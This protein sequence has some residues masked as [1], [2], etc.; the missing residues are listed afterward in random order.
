MIDERWRLNPPKPYIQT[1]QTGSEQG[2]RNLYGP[3]L[4]FRVPLDLDGDADDT[5]SS[6]PLH[7]TEGRAYYFRMEHSSSSSSAL[8]LL[9]L[10]MTKI[11]IETFTSTEITYVGDET[12]PVLPPLNMTDFLL[13]NPQGFTTCLTDYDDSTDIQSQ[14]ACQDA[15]YPICT[16]AENDGFNL[17]YGECYGYLYTEEEATD[18]YEQSFAAQNWNALSNLQET[19]LGQTPINTRGQA[20][21]SISDAVASKTSSVTT[22]SVVTKLDEWSTTFDFGSPYGHGLSMEFF[23]EIS[24]TNKTLVDDLGDLQ[25]KYSQH[26]S[27]DELDN[28]RVAEVEVKVGFAKSEHDGNLVAS[29][30]PPENKNGTTTSLFAPPDS[31]TFRYSWEETPIITSIFPT[32]G[33]VGDTITITGEQF[34]TIPSTFD[35]D[36]G[37]GKCIPTYANRTVVL[38]DLTVE[39][40]AGVWDVVVTQYREGSAM[41]SALNSGPMTFEVLMRVDSVFPND[42]SLYGGAAVTISGSGFANFGLYNKVVFHQPEWNLNV[43]CIPR[44]M[45]NFECQLSENDPGLECGPDFNFD[46]IDHYDNPIHSRGYSHFFDFSNKTQIECDME[47]IEIP[48][49]TKRS[50]NA[51]LDGLNWT[52]SVQLASEEILE[53]EEMLDND[54]VDVMRSYECWLIGPSCKMFSENFF[55]SDV[56][57]GDWYNFTGSRSTLGSAIN[58]NYNA[59]AVIEEA[60]TYD[61]DMNPYMP[62]DN[63]TLYAMAGQILTLRGHGFSKAFGATDKNY[64]KNRYSFFDQRGAEEIIVGER[65]CRTI[66]LNDT[67][68]KCV[69]YF[70]KEDVVDPIN[71][72]V[73][74]KGF[75]E[76]DWSVMFGLDIYDISPKWGSVMGGTEVTITGSGE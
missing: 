37:P 1:P 63:R 22:T 50:A 53:D 5:T 68:A 10:T 7:L 57:F 38:C 2:R 41:I 59:T 9:S 61:T 46:R 66:E 24:V 23:R 42:I 47:R 40:V 70:Q 72:Q 18:I 6:I 60:M 32:S 48:N 26:T 39:A 49:P 12:D 51:P 27:I 74:G 54:L 8:K 17:T 31:C 55:D 67:H 44:V 25:A 36:V 29:C 45:R 56:F 76:C 30:Y 21:I 14:L 62:Y 11:K 64:Y 58:T 15:S 19:N 20:Q 71:L 28:E 75:A 13:P 69:L 35:I 43:S 34:G 4:S 16:G 33:A 3:D 73:Y 65:P 52:V